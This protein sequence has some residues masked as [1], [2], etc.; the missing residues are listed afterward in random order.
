[1]KD[2]TIWFL[3]IITGIFITAAMRG[4]YE[5]INRLYF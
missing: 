1:M 3:G 5:T 2:F 4:V